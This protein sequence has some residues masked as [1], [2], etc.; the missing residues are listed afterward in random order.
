[1]KKLSELYDTTTTIVEITIEKIINFLICGS[2]IYFNNKRI[3]A[4]IIKIFINSLNRG[5]SFTKAVCPRYF[6][7]TIIIKDM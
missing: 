5:Y 6:E 7:P 3:H 2:K 4:I 1:M